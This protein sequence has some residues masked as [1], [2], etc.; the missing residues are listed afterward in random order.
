M[1]AASVFARS[2][3]GA[4]EVEPAW[5]AGNLDH[6]DVV[7]LRD[8]EE[9]NGEW[10][11]ISGARWVPLSQLESIAAGWDRSRPMVLVDRAGRRATVAALTLE[12]AGFRQVAALT[13]GMIRW[14]EG[15]R[16]VSHAW[17]VQAL[18]PPAPEAPAVEGALDADF[19]LRA[20]ASPGAVRWTSLAALLVTGSQSC[21]DGRDA[22]AVL[23]S[24][25]G[26]AGELLLALAAVEDLR[27]APLTPEQV[28]CALDAVLLHFGRLYMHTDR[29]ALDHLA[30][31]LDADRRFE[32]A[33]VGNLDALERWIARPPRA[34]EEPLLQHLV[35]PDNN[36]CGHL[37]L[38]LSVAQEYGLRPR[39]ARMVLEAIHRARW[40]GGA[41]DL[42]TLEGHHDEQ[43]I[44]LVR[45]DEPLHPWSRVP[46]IAPRLGGRQVFVHHP[47]VACWLREQ[48][49]SLI[50]S[51]SHLLPSVDADALAARMRTLGER[52]L[53][54]TLTRL[55][56]GLPVH[57]VQ[58][59][60]GDAVTVDDRTA[61]LDTRR[62]LA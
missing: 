19:V 62:T 12:R 60:D 58:F 6:V 49:A 26:D 39:L 40:R 32:D 27:G 61:T 3:S 33:P 34:L 47:Q 15:G 38:T 50:T 22:N 51:E 35:Q 17:D 57:H 10:G 7:D 14:V 55:A 43:A 44:L 11:H 8:Q 5:L 42:V 48:L 28:G 24:P 56:D 18:V 31:A 54:A 16:P 4:P 37:R 13:G 21:V 2:A 41:V 52:Q 30:E 1:A 45:V 59:G 23:G 25:G 29:H 20:L 9:L 36:G 46:M 53:Q